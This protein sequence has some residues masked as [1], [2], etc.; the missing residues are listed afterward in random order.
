MIEVVIKCIKIIN[1]NHRKSIAIEMTNQPWWNEMIKSIFFLV[2]LAFE[3]G[4]AVGTFS[5]AS[6]AHWVG[7]W[8]RI[9]RNT[10]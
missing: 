10:E 5:S 7:R 6:V 8:G 9:D 1:S 4:G 3:N 2:L